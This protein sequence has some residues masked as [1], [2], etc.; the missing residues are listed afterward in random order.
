MKE[1]TRPGNG[2]DPARFALAR[3][4]ILRE[5]PTS[6]K[7]PRHKRGQ[8]FLCGPVPLPWLRWAATLRGKAVAVGIALWFKA[9]V[10][11]RAEVKATGSL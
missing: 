11:K 2:L 10:T 9:G 7:P 8:K 4:V 3:P 6:Q 5:I 1:Y